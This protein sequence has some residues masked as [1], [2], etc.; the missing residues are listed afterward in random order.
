MISN[1]VSSLLRVRNRSIQHVPSLHAQN[2]CLTLV[3]LKP[4]TGRFHQ[5]R[6]QLAWFCGCPIVGDTTY[7]GGTEPSLKFRNRGMFLCA[8]SV[9]L[10]HSF[11]IDEQSLPQSLYEQQS[12]EC[13]EFS[14]IKSREWNACTH[15]QYS[16]AGQLRK[17]IATRAGAIQQICGGRL[18]FATMMVHYTLFLVTFHLQRRIF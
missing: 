10:Q 6:R 3:E 5:L 15:L 2:G 14:N 9:R 16:C 13:N 18:F 7:D 12:S 11:Y 4:K 17:P 1:F 8:S